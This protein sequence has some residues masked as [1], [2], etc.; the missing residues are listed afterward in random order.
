[1]GPWPHDP[2]PVLLEAGD[3][4]TWLVDL[5]LAGAKSTKLAAPEARTATPAVTVTASPSDL[6]LTLYRRQPFSEPQVIGERDV[7]DRLLTWPDLD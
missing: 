1:M 7:L 3:G 2:V 4:G 6:V 5:G